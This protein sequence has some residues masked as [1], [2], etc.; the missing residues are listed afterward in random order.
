ME[1]EIIVHP[2]TL[3]QPKKVLSS[4]NDHRI[5]M[6]LATLCTL[7]GGV[8]EGAEAVKKSFPNYYETIETLG[9]HVTREVLDGGNGYEL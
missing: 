5:A 6:T 1:N 3:Q 8:I 2:G 7:T 4:H 9:I